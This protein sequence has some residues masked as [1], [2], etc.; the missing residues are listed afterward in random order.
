M[1]NWDKYGMYALIDTSK[2]RIAT[3][4]SGFKILWRY[5]SNVGHLD[6]YVN[7]ERVHTIVANYGAN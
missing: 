7:N 6:F 4:E 3:S 5:E 2:I 1:L